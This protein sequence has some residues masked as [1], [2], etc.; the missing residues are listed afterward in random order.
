MIVVSAE[1]RN[2]NERADTVLVVPLSRSVHHLAP[3]HV[4]LPAAETGLPDDSAA[5]ADSLTTVRKVDLLE[6]R[7]GLRCLSNARICQLAE[8]TQIAM[9]CL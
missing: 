8:A 7:T 9:D 2:R 3:T 4:V 5:R 1:P 6:P